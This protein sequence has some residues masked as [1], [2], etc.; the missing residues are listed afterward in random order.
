MNNS[1][2]YF[3]AKMCCYAQEHI[4]YPGAWPIDP[5]SRSCYLQCTSYSVACFISLNTVEGVHGVESDIVIKELVEYPAKSEQEWR[6][7]INKLSTLYGGWK[8]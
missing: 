8:E 3:L 4:D 7:I 6:Y 2:T 1:L 5:A